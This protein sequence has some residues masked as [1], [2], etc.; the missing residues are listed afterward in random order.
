MRRDD[1]SGCK[2]A[3]PP[4]RLN[5][6]A[7]QVWRVQQ[8]ASPESLARFHSF[9]SSDEQ[10][11][12]DQFRFEHLKRSYTLSRGV[13]RLLLAFYLDQHPKAI[14]FAYGPKGKPKICQATPVCFNA[15]HS[16]DIAVYA[17]SL[18][19]ELGIDVEKVRELPDLESI[20]S[21]FFC[22]AEAS[23]LQ[24]LS[25]NDRCHAFFRCWTRKEAYVKAVGDGLSM[26]LDRFQVTLLPEDP[27]RFV[28]IGNDKK[29]AQT[30]ALHHLDFTPQC[31]GALAYQDKPRHIEFRA[32]VRAEDLLTSLTILS[33]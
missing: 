20:S 19:C 23:E 7:V 26:P 10:H 15:S 25:A 31:V 21:R 29:A 27:V 12:I 28:H 2:N 3:P 14:E 22:A 6:G 24:S 17:F 1:D 4:T 16:A 30:W 5:P 9:L 33:G 32:L 8:S 11:R 13:L 18:D